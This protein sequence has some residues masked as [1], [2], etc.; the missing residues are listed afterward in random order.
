[1]LALVLQVDGSCTKGIQSSGRNV[2]SRCDPG[3]S[4]GR[5]ILFSLGGGKF[6][7]DFLT[8]VI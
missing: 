6:R 3:E 7:E 1:M 2:V 5:G 8:E 4:R